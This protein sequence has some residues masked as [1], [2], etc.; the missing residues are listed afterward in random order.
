MPLC[1]P[2]HCSRRGHGHGQMPA[3]GAPGSELGS[4][5]ADSDRIR[6]SER[7]R[8]CQIPLV[9]APRLGGPVLHARVDREHGLGAAQEDQQS[10]VGLT[11]TRVV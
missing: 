7:Q 9:P 3:P 5:R 10:G 4:T 8:R 2:F 6:R 1:G 11:R